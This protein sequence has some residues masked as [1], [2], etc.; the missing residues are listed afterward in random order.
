MIPLLPQPW[1]AVARLAAVVLVALSLYAVGRYDGAAHVR[2][3][4]AEEKA[5]QARQRG[6]LEKTYR[7]REQAYVDHLRKAEN[8]ANQRETALRAAAA[9]AE[10]ANRGLRDDLARIAA[11]MPTASAD[12]CRQT[13]LAALAVFGHCADEYRSLAEVADRHASDVRTLTEAWPK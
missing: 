1:G 5:G 10:R 7:E 6:Y 4:W 12:A 13:A 2:R 9:A 11:G 8:E 3:A